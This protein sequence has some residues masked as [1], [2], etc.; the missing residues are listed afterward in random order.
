MNTLPF[1]VSRPVEFSGSKQ[2]GRG[3]TAMME[4][5]DKGHEETPPPNTDFLQGV[6][7]VVIWA[8]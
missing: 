2:Q 5:A 8:S 4:A 1:E 7:Y 3:K 6:D